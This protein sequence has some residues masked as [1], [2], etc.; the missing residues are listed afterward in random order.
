MRMELVDTPTF[1]Q[2]R[3]RA[4]FEMSTRLLPAI[5]PDMILFSYLHP[6]NA[7]PKGLNGARYDNPQLTTLLESARAEVNPE[8]RLAMYAEVQRI[9]LVDL[10]YQPLYTSNVVWPGKPNVSGVRINYL[11]Q[12]NFHDV[13]IT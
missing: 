13:N 11:G 10:F 3:N 7:A 1:N 9:A 8:K 5:N 12:V 2:R 6:A 4:E